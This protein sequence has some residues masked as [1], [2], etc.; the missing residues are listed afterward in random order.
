MPPERRKL[1]GFTDNRQDAALQ[2][3]HFNDFLF[4]A[5]LRAAM[6]A[7]VR[8]A[9]P[10]GLSEDEFGRRLQA[11]LGFTPPIASGG[12]SGCSTPRS[13][14]RS[15]GR[16]RPR[17][18]LARVLAH[19]AWVDQRRGWRFTNPNLEELGLVRADYVSLDEL[20]ADDGAFASAPPELRTASPETRREGAPDL[21][22]II[23]A[24]AWRSRP[25]RSTLST[26]KRLAMRRARACASRGRSRN[27]RPASVAA[28]L[29]IDAPK[30]AD[31]GLR[32][33]PLIVR[34]GSRSLL[35]RKLGRASI[36]GKRLE[37]RT[38]GEVVAALLAGGCAVSVG[39]T[40]GDP[41]DVRAGALRRTRFVS[42]P[43]RTRRRQAANPYFAALYRKLA[44]ALARGG[45]GL[46]GSKAAN[47]RPRSIRRDES[48]ANGAS[49][50]AKRTAKICK[51]A[52]EELRLAGEPN[53]FLPALFCSPTMELGVDISALNAVYMR[54]MPPTPAN[55]AQRSGRAGRSGQAALVVTYCS[56]QGPHDQYYFRARGRW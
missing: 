12:R 53:V 17:D 43:R 1:L 26:S 7:A 37:S 28:A 11:A 46:F 51:A 52:R 41:F 22:W 21:A 36:W 34:G 35:A 50:G 27:R 56:A 55:Y 48:G 9:G 2:A 8:A 29:I 4:V 20:A 3:G 54:N 32:G 18:T 45:E 15:G 6:L 44:D 24:R 40:G 19:R 38:Y 49:A 16:R 5:L 10:D 14:R 31:A 33:E 47:T 39:Q 23:S 42:S 25:M 30:R 13:R